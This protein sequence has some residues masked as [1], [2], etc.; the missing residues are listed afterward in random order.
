MMK[1]SGQRNN[2]VRQYK[3]SE[4][5]RLQWTPEL[6]GHFVD[7][8]E[9]LGGR[10]KATPKRIVQ[11]M[12]VKGLKISHVKSHLQMYRN[13]RERTTFDVFVA[14]ESCNFRDG[15]LHSSTWAPQGHTFERLLRQ[16]FD[17]SEEENKLGCYFSGNNQR[18]ESNP[19]GH[20]LFYQESQ[21]SL[22]C[23]MTTTKAEED[24][25]GP[26]DES[27]EQIP[28]SA[29]NEDDR[30]QVSPVK[31]DRNSHSGAASTD[32]VDLRH[33]QSTKDS[34]INLDLSISCLYW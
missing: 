17:E 24:G 6:H 21:G 20:H 5:P 22:N 2:G 15:R 18:N 26:S 30:R 28:Q 27:F 14:A 19:I 3:K 33:L 23:E 31:D 12:A 32:T 29:Y 11:M 4:L 8:V 10:Y 13:M 1:S 9:H 16:S 34:K 7:A 25:G